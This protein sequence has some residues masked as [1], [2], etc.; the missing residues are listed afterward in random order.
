MMS[1]SQRL[2]TIAL[3]ALLL[4]AFLGLELSRATYQLNKEVSVRSTSVTTLT[5]TQVELNQILQRAMWDVPLVS[6]YEH[7]VY[8]SGPAAT[9]NCH[10]ANGY[11]QVHNIHA[12]DR[13]HAEFM[14]TG[15]H[16]VLCVRAGDTAQV[17]ETWQ[18]LQFASDVIAQLNLPPQVVIS[19]E[20]DAYRVSMNR[21]I[22][23]L[24]GY[25]YK[26]GAPDDT[27]CDKMDGYIPLRSEA[28]M[29]RKTETP[30]TVCVIP[31]TITATA[32]TPIGYY[33]Q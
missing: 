29:V 27:D 22:S 18:S 31:T 4:V 28:V 3:L 15:G 17:D 14:K 19:T 20:G 10:S 21:E 32:A 25:Q 13:V 7:F 16:H 6:N 26:F 5:P 9:T 33:L 23:E 8:K 24:A 30:A 11:S 2:Q 1:K 12:F